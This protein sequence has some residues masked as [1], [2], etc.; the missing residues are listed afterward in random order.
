MS[1]ELALSA[2][3]GAASA[4]RFIQE[5][6]A[7]HRE[8]YMRLVEY[9]EQCE[10]NQR[11]QP[12]M[13]DGI[14]FDKA[15]D[16][17]RSQLALATKQW[18]DSTKRLQSFEKLVVPEKRQSSEQITQDEGERV[19]ATTMVYFREGV[20]TFIQDFC[21]SVLSC[22]SLRG[23]D[24]RETDIYQLS[25]DKLRTAMRNA[26]ESGTSAGQLPAWVRKACEG[27]I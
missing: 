23:K 18:D 27:A 3:T 24:F 20:E 9:L 8:R 2:N 12:A 17:A 14:D 5:D 21:A 25:A 19:L 6:E 7:R 26:I 11:N 13:M 10:A 1:E 22:E 15:V 4:L 16:I